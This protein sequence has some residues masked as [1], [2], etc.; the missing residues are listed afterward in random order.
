[1]TKIMELLNRTIWG[2]PALILILGVGLFLTVKTGGAQLTLFPRACKTFLDRLRE[3]KSGQGGVSPF[4]ALCTALAATVGTGNLAGVAGAMAIGG[5]GAI[6]WM[7]C[8]AVLGMVTK[9]A[10]ATLAVRYRTKDQSGEYVGG[11][12]YMI[13]RGMGEHWAWLGSVYCFFGVVAAFGVGN[14]TQ[15][16]A[17]IGGI[18]QAVTAF[19]GQESKIGNLIMGVLL[20]IMVVLMLLGGAKRIGMIAE[21]LVP[22]AAAAY[23]LLGA[24]VLLVRHEQIPSAFITIVQGA[25]SPQAVTGGMVGSAFQAMRVGVSR[26]VFTNEAGMGTASIAHGAAKVRHPVEQGL[27]GIMEVFL[28]TVVICTMTALVILCSGVPIPYG[29]DTGV[30]LTTQAF[31]AV[32]GNWASVLIA[33]SLCCFAFAT[34]LGWGLYG[35]RCAQYLFGEKAWR[36]FAVLQ[37]GIVILGAVLNTGTVWILSEIFNGLMAIPNL[38]ALAAL[39]PELARLTKEYKRKFGRKAAN[40]GTYENLNQCKSL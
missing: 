30:A 29:V 23:L 1:M 34:I 4:Q 12:M 31:S 40:G 27:M 21:R 7:W 37:G 10:E 11:P 39:S 8:C 16:N 3:E 35:A 25:F 28:D 19:G 32:Y 33:L 2:V 6:F 38:I 18:N 26:G 13:R 17:V 9:F 20:G 22:F 14:A 15:V 24:G 5:P 36:Y